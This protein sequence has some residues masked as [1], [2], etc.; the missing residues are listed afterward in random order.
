MVDETVDKVTDKPKMTDK[1]TDKPKMTDKM[2]N[3]VTDKPKMTDKMTQ[4]KELIISYIKQNGQITNSEA[5]EILGTSPATAKRL[6][7][8]MVDDKTL[9]EEGEYKSRKYRLLEN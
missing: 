7:R 2:T 3:K 6:M 4:R 8:E 9:V 1:V 5:R